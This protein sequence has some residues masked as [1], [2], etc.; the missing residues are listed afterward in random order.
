MPSTSYWER[1]AILTE[2]QELIASGMTKVR[3]VATLI[4]RHMISTATAYRYWNA[5]WHEWDAARRRTSS[6][7]RLSRAIATADHI[8]T[9][10]AQRQVEMKDGSLRTA[11]D[12]KL[13]LEALNM[14][15]KLLGLLAPERVVLEER[16]LR[17]LMAGIIEVARTTITLKDDL[18]SFGRGVQKLFG[19]NGGG[20]Q[21]IDASP[22]KRLPPPRL[23]GQ[24][25]GTN[26]ST[27]SNGTHG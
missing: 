9:V 20:A 13:W 5:A 10:A 22:P 18:I 2:T 1:R 8:K 3:V 21:V 27:S 23:P 26:G 25:G 12:G 15:M 19:L 24:D 6:D 4:E 16:D 14:E 11:P 17:P 7:H